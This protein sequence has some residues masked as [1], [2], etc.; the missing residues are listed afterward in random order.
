VDCGSFDTQCATAACDANGAEGNCDTLT[1]RPSGTPCDNDANA[2][3]V[4]ECDLGGN[5]LYQSDVACASPAGECDGGQTCDPAT[6]ACMDN[7]D[8]PAE[9][10]CDADGNACTLDQCDGG[11]VCA[12]VSDVECA[13]PLNECDGGQSCDPSSGE[14]TDNADA[15]AETPCDTDDSACT[16]D[17]CDGSGACVLVSTVECPGPLN[18]C[19]GGQSCDPAS[20]TCADNPDVAAETPCDADGD[21]CT[22]DQCDGGGACL[23]VSNVECPGP[24]NQCDAGQSCD[25]LSGEC[26]DALDPPAG[27]A[28]DNDANLCTLDVCDGLGNCVLDDQVE[29]AAST[30]VCDGGQTCQPS[31]GECVNNDDAPEGAPCDLDTN[32][33]T[34]DACDGAGICVAGPECDVLPVCIPHVG[35]DMPGPP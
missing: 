32:L 20:G 33:C 14:C 30:G 3:T 2:C 8:A 31:T 23:F 18:A 12:F 13:A 29:C 7:A 35:C 9:T 22:V 34:Q 6:G 5:C 15:P 26:A 19:D 4:D 1:A 17:H 16:I 28:C 11:G 25:S 24:V 10:D 21:A 27:T